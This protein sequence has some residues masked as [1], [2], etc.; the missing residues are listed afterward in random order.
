MSEHLSG[1]I[2]ILPSVWTVRSIGRNWRIWS[3]IPLNL[4]KS[5]RFIHCVSDLNFRILFVI[6][7]L[8][9]DPLHISFTHLFKPCERIRD[10]LRGFNNNY[11]KDTWKFG[12]LNAEISFIIQNHP[13]TWSDV[14]SLNRQLMDKVK[15]I[16]YI[17]GVVNS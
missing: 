12:N 13:F 7:Y 9:S 1:T 16:I 2:T 6:D 14:H 17:N 5:N 3:A 4:I 8:I 11:F 10:C 15:S